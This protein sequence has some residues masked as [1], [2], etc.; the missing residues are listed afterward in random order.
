MFGEARTRFDRYKDSRDPVHVLVNFEHSPSSK[1]VVFTV[2][3]K[4][5]RKLYLSYK[6]VLKILKNIQVCKYTPGESNFCQ[7]RW[8]VGEVNNVLRGLFHTQTH[9]PRTHPHTHTHTHT[10]THG[11]THTCARTPTHAHNTSRSGTM[12]GDKTSCSVYFIITISKLA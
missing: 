3:K 4:Q 10:H 8:G 9:T 5:F 1:F 6:K 12:D 11:H 7:N 2:N